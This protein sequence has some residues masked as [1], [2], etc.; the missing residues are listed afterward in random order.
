MQELCQIKTLAKPNANRYN[1]VKKKQDGIMSEQDDSR[2]Q[3]KDNGADA[4]STDYAV[5]LGY[6]HTKQAAPKVLA[7][8]QRPIAQ[9]I[10][11]IAIDEGIEIRRDA[12]LVQILKAVDID[13]EIPVEAFAAVA[14]II[15]YVYQVNNK[16]LPET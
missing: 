5:A 15:S 1:Y 8:G 6:D 13:E 14:E 12:D 3:N 4:L 9:K 10:V 11:Q 2:K 7:K 16:Q